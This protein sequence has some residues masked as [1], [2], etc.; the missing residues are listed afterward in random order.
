MHSK[1]LDF[2]SSLLK[3]LPVSVTCG[4]PPSSSSPT[5]LFTSFFFVYNVSMYILIAFELA[6]FQYHENFCTQ[7][8]SSTK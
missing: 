3:D 1:A 8:F 7:I 6:C 5:E 4:Y 2:F